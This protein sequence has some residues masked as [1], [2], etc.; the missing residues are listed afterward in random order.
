L[1]T[2]TALFFCL[3][4]ISLSYTLKDYS[5][6]KKEVEIGQ[7]HFSL[8]PV[9]VFKNLSCIRLHWNLKKRAWCQERVNSVVI[10]T[11]KLK[12]VIILNMIRFTFF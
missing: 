9:Q 8:G 7:K 1:L 10:H 11:V 2:L 6:K 3:A 5:L 4:P 12:N